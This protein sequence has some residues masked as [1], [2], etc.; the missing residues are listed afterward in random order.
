MSILMIKT[1]IILVCL[2]RMLLEWRECE[3]E[4][5]DRVVH[6]DSNAQKVLQRCGLYKLWK[7]GS[8]RSQPR[9]LQM[10]VDYW[11]A[12]TEAFMLHG[13]PLRLKVDDIYFIYSLSR[14]GEVV[15]IWSHGV[16]GGL[17]I[18]EYIAT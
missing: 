16:G 4:D 11:D 1:H 10:F 15:N 17:T 18:D 12:D 8:L 13:I 3:H 5:F 6:G 9:L 2:R 7:L 14:W